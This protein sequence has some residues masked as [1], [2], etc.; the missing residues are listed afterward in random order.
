LCSQLR[1]FF[2]VNS[3]NIELVSKKHRRNIEESTKKSSRKPKEGRFAVGTVLEPIKGW[4]TNIRYNY[5]YRAGSTVNTMYPVEVH[6]ANGTMGNIG[7]AQTGIEEELRT[8]HYSVFTAYSQYE[9]AIDKHYFSAMAGYEH[10][11]EFNR[12][13]LGEGYDLISVD[14]PSISTALGNKVLDDV[15]NHWAT[16]GIFG[17][18]NY[19]F[20]EKY[21][22]EVSAR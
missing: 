12:N 10:D 22:L 14:V 4:T 15:I 8:G 9:K 3:L 17:R 18:F 6:V 1:T 2:V 5:T 19:N 16:Q 20:D 13:L 7:F 21:L 11:Y